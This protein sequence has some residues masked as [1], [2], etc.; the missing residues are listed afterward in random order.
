MGYSPA[1]VRGRGSGCG[2]ARGLCGKPL[3]MHGPVHARARFGS[4]I[5]SPSLL[6]ALLGCSP[7]VAVHSVVALTARRVAVRLGDRFRGIKSS[8]THAA[9]GDDGDAVRART[10]KP[11]GA[12]PLR[13]GVQ[14]HASVR[15]RWRRV[16]GTDRSSTSS[17]A[18][19]VAVRAPLDSL[20]H[21]T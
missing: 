2:C 16:A 18:G 1:Y 19:R 14:A 5:G 8:W 15:R 7:A 4:L 17:P 20:V 12:R 13:P 21:L 10:A 9:P 3:R 11:A 6:S